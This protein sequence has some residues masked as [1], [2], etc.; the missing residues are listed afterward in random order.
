MVTVAIKMKTI[1]AGPKGT[2]DAGKV[3]FVSAEEAKELV[4]ANFAS[5]ETTMVQ[6]PV[7]FTPEAEK[8]VVE[9]P[10]KAAKG[11]GQVSPEKAAVEAPKSAW[12]KA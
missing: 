2:K 8:A 4:D 5:Y 3:Y 1:D 12:G 7:P 9:P 6:N 11:K 10:E